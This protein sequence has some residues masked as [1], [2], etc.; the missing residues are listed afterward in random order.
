M[1]GRPR[2]VQAVWP[3]RRELCGDPALAILAALDATLSL[4]ILTLAANHPSLSDC[5]RPYYLPPLSP[6]DKVAERL[7]PI[8][9]KLQQALAAYR[10]A[11]AQ[12]NEAERAG[13][14][15]R[16]GIPF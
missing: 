1:T 15:S 12:E 3:D 14:S 9:R 8:G 16:N 7:I 4:A 13:L 2:P 11:V 10:Q 5:E 6:S